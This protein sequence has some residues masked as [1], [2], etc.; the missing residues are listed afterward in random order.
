MKFQRIL[1]FLLVISKSTFAQ[2]PKNLWQP[3]RITERDGAQHIDLSGDGWE[4]SHTDRPVDDIRAARKDAFPTSIPNSVHWSYYKAGKLP[5]P[6]YNKNSVLYKFTDEKVWYYRKSFKN[7]RKNPN[8]LAFLCFDG[9]DYF[10]K[11]WVNDTLVGVHEGMFGGPTIE[12]SKLLK[13]DNEILIEV[14]AGNWENKGEDYE[15][16]PRLPS[17]NRNNSDSKGY[18]PRKTG[19][20]IRPWLVGGGNGVEMF[21]PVG[22]WR[23]VRIE[24]MGNQHLERPF[25]TTKNINEKEVELELNFEIFVNSHSLLHEIHPTGD[26]QLNMKGDQKRSISQFEAKLEITDKLSKKVYAHTIP[27]L[28]HE[29]RNW[30]RHSFKLS[31]AELWYPNGIGDAYLYN[32]RLIL[33]DNNE[34]KDELIFNYGIRAI[35]HL[36]SAGPQLSDRWYNWQYEV[37]GQKLF[38]KGINWMFLDPLLEA[39]EEKYRWLLESAKNAGIQMIRVNGSCLIESDTFFDIC[40]ELGLMVESDFPLGN[41]T[42]PLYPQDIWESQVVQNIIRLRNHPSLVV[43]SGGNEFNA[44]HKDNTVVIGILERNLAT[45]DGTRPFYRTDPDGGAAHPYPDFDPVWYK[46]VHGN[47]PWISEAGIHSL[48]EAALF[49]ETVNP[50]ELEGGLGNMYKEDFV[51]THP[52]FVHHFT[53]YGPDRVPR[54]LSRASHIIDISNPTLDEITEASQIGAGEFYQIMSEKFQ[55]NYPVTTGLLPWVLM[56]TW[57][58]AGIQLIDGFGNAGAPYYFLKRTYEPTHIAMDL[59]RLL[60]KSGEE[61]D[62]SVAVTHAQPDPIEEA[63][64]SITVF[65]DAFK[66]VSKLSKKISIKSGPS[67]TSQQVG[68]YNIP[69]NYKDRFILLLAEVRNAKGEMLSRSF[70]YPRV[71]KKMDDPVFYNKYISEPTPW[72]TLEKGPWLKSVIGKASTRLMLDMISIQRLHENRSRLKVKITNSGKIPAFM[73][74]VDIMGIKRATFMSDNY[75]WLSPGE[76]KEVTIDVLWR[77]SS[78]IDKVIISVGAWNAKVISKN[79]LIK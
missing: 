11:V 3:Y 74:K 64:V 20:V 37:N 67:V 70:Y 72:V 71:L 28:L 58:T 19:K 66:P 54:M 57:P 75:M 25:L 27:L 38:V 44:Y 61:I 65:D 62:L 55:S 23:G 1:F 29:G 68:K 22:I 32:V 8:D 15:L 36:P 12:I 46:I 7:P 21:F 52:E 17:G 4:L 45:F 18:D 77:E 39:N 47:N 26:V 41:Q 2:P 51:K 14:R 73:T 63:E 9:V 78:A 76:N 56:R 79:Q 59:K 6:Y 60:W 24:I 48:P 10:S 34:I 33:K 69:E 42:A 16:L 40:D 53:E 13:E 31:D 43:W 30:M 50:A 35:N 5:H 49:R